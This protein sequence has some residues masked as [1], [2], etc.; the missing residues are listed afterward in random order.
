MHRNHKRFVIGINK[1]PDVF[2]GCRREGPLLSQPAPSPEQ[3]GNR[4][5]GP[6]PQ[7]LWASTAFVVDDGCAKRPGSLESPEAPQ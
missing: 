1:G 7:I 2:E 4:S 5:L 6:E 3:I